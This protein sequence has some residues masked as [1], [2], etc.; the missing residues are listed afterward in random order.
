VLNLAHIDLKS[1]LLNF[2]NF[3]SQLTKA[4]IKDKFYKCTIKYT[5]KTKN[6][7][8]KLTTSYI[9]C[10]SPL[11]SILLRLFI[12]MVCLSCKHYRT[13]V[14]HDS[15]KSATVEVFTLQISVTA[16]SKG[17]WILIVYT[18]EMMSRMLI[19]QIKNL[20]VWCL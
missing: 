10:Y 15:L 1:A 17:C 7:Y 11:L 3:V 13:V 12:K 8:S 18:P 9:F 5:T 4:T 6:K 16:T 2:R 20:N 14:S 19:M